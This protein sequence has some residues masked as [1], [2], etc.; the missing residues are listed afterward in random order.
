MDR[1]SYFL[2]A[3][4]KMVAMYVESFKDIIIDEFKVYNFTDNRSVIMIESTKRKNK[5]RIELSGK[6]NLSDAARSVHWFFSHYESN[7]TSAS[8]DV[9][10]AL[11]YKEK[12]FGKMEELWRKLL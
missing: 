3:I 12:N 9:N 6:Y 8:R 7:I 2:N 1:N 5:V 11:Y 4:K 10:D